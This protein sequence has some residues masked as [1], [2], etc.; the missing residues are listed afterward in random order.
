MKKNLTKTAFLFA[1]C[2]LFSVS[3]FA[4]SHTITGVILDKDNGKPLPGV[5]I[6]LKGTTSVGTMTNDKGE[7]SLKVNKEGKMVLIISSIGYA[8]TEM[9]VSTNATLIVPAKVMMRRLIVSNPE[10]VVGY[11]T[12]DLHKLIGSVGTYKPTEEPGQLPL[13]IDDA[14]VGKVAGVYV[15]PSSGVP[16]SASAITIRGISSLTNNGNSPLIVVDGTPIYG[17]D[18]NMNTTNFGQVSQGFSFGGTQTVSDYDPSGQNQNSFEKNPLATINPDDI[19]SIE[20]LKDAFATAIYGSRG[21]AGVILITTKKG[22]A[23]SMKIDAQIST[24]I[25]KP[26]KLPSV[27]NGDQYADFYSNYLTQMNHLNYNPD[28]VI[29]PKGVNT[30]WLDAVTRTAVG[31]DVALSLSG[32]NDK[33]G[34]YYISGGYNKAQSYII[35]NDFTRYQTRIKFDQEISKILTIGTNIAVSYA[36]NNALNAQSIYRNAALKGPNEY[37]KDSLGNY[38]WEFA[39]NPTGPTAINGNPWRWQCKTQIIV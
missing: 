19:A 10:V 16:G 23:G 24:S 7:F 13:T 8:S 38:Q 30:N 36:K 18:Q 34:T 17:I 4:Q 20:I 1:C 6:R 39:P 11:G 37:I 29:F 2:L 15:A 35:R 14:L 33:G 21:A 27:M 5:S 32:G 25:S 12:Q 9:P 28:T 26:F 31:T 22:Q 3:I